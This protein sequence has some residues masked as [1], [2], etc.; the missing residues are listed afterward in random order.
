M[1]FIS[2]T[3]QMASFKLH[4]KFSIL[5]SESSSELSSID[6]A[7]FVIATKSALFISSSV[8]NSQISSTEQ[9][10]DDQLLNKLAVI[11]ALLFALQYTG[12][13]FLL[14]PF[15]DRG[16]NDRL[17]NIG[18]VMKSPDALLPSDNIIRGLETLKPRTVFSFFTNLSHQPEI[19][20]PEAVTIL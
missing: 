18:V 2:T 3:L 9:S 15:I 10:N 13:L 17:I 19:F 4:E 8:T 12:K 5:A 14:H 6:N 11:H 20:D 1:I 7:S 16:F